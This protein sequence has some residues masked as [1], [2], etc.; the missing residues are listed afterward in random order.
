[1]MSKTF[2]LFGFSQSA[3]MLTDTFRVLFKHKL[4]LSLCSKFTAVS[5][6]RKYLPSAL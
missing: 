5:S 4:S 6:D 2:W 3:E 1:M